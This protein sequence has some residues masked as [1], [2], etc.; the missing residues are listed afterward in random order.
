MT[1]G[2]DV[3]CDEMSCAPFGRTS[4]GRGSTM[5]F[6]FSLN[7]VVR[8]CSMPVL[9]RQ[10]FMEADNDGHL[11]ECQP[12]KQS[13]KAAEK[14]CRL[15]H[16][17]PNVWRK[18]SGTLQGTNISPQNGILKMI[19]LFPRWDM[20]I[21][22]RVVPSDLSDFCCWILPRFKVMVLW[23]QKNGGNWWLGSKCLWV[24]G[25][26]FEPKQKH[27]EIQWD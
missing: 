21:P 12:K 9:R 17:V 2:I 7:Q 11:E 4:S 24:F 25:W 26:F 27:N 18:E 23:A 14:C 3:C 13:Q 8:V 10:L 22:W 6:G 1:L 20:L 5:S 15:A 19:F 16:L